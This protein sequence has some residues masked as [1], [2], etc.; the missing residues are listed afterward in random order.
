MSARQMTQWIKTFEIPRLPR[1]EIHLWRVNLDRP[2]TE[3]SQ[4]EKL[5]SA[6][7]QE[8]A[9]QFHFTRDQSRFIVRHAVRRQLLSKH[10]GIAPTALKIDSGILQKPKIAAQLNPQGLRFNCSHSGDWAL[11]ALARELE[12]GVD[13]E[14]HQPLPD[15]AELAQSFFSD[16][17]INELGRLPKSLQL[18]GF[19]DCW[20][21][22]EAFVKAIGLGLSFPL[23]HFSVTLAP[24]RPAMLLE[25]TGDPH[26]MEKWSMLSPDFLA[27]HSTA[28]VFDKAALDVKFFEWSFPNKEFSF[29]QNA[30]AK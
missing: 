28:L 5:M 10:L 1:S 26:A 4:L 2:T 6:A 14:Q 12:V 13:L 29:N 22:K 21:R 11:I 8:Q 3:V 23:N 30:R 19:F 24:D 25:V 7:E 9:A 27:N 15:A 18:R 20:T 16:L 17:E